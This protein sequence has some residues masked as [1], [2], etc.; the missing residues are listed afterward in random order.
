MAADKTRRPQND[1]AR[2]D[3]D[4]AIAEAR[5]GETWSDEA[6][7]R[8]SNPRCREELV[9]CIRERIWPGILTIF[10]ATELIPDATGKDGQPEIH[11]EWS[12]ETTM[13]FVFLVGSTEDTGMGIGDDPYFCRIT[14]KVRPRGYMF[15]TDF[16]IH[17]PE[18]FE[19]ERLKALLGDPRFAGNPPKLIYE[20]SHDDSPGVLIVEFRF[21]R[22]F[23][24]F[25]SPPVE[26]ILAEL[27]EHVNFLRRL[28]RA[29]RQL[30]RD[31]RSEPLFRQVV[32]ELE[33]CFQAE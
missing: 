18:A 16:Y 3:L 29:V 8:V 5:R 20:V 24:H 17:F 30:S 27:A 22:G 6:T 14:T 32:N 2:K 1:W 7:V 4:A 9:A 10:H 25:V 15:E 11:Q 28:I 13:S 12:P 31:Y 23:E 21:G 33:K 26:S 19:M